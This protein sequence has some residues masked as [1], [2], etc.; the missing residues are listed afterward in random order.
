MAWLNQAITLALCEGFIEMVW[1]QEYRDKPKNKTFAVMRGKLKRDIAKAFE[2]LNRLSRC[3]YTKKVCLLV[4]EGAQ[5]MKADMFPT[6]NF[7]ILVALGICIE[8]VLFQVDVA[9]PEKARAYD[10]VYFRLQEI[11]RYFDHQKNF[12]D[13]QL[14]DVGDRIRAIIR[15]LKK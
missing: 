7:N 6:G 3:A 9:G 11:I 2:T 4:D 13:P 15:G 12:D 5:R 1:E 14:Y 10:Q 8:L